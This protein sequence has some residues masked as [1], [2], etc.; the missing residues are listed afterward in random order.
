MA[1]SHRDYVPQN[2]TLFLSFLKKIVDYVEDQIHVDPPIWTH[3]DGKRFETL[4]D[5]YQ[6]FEKALNQAESTPTPA[7]I[8]ARNIA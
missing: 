7:N 1:A 8:Q 3:V 5:R 2:A 6:A 4:V